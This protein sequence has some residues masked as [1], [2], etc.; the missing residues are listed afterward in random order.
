[1]NGS[2]AAGPRY[3]LNFVSRA[4]L[5]RET[6]LLAGLRRPG[7]SW[8]SVRDRAVRENAVQARTHRSGVRLTREAVRRLVVLS[9]DE[10]E[11]LLDAAPRE[12][13]YLTWAA[14]CRAYPFIG[15]FAEQV[16]RE[17]Y[18][19][20][21]L[22][23]LPEHLEAFVLSQAMWHAELADLSD[24]MESGIR[25]TVFRMMREADLVTSDGE[26][27]PALLSGRLAELLT[28]AGRNDL[29]FFPTRGA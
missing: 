25:Q 8:E 2:Y 4:L 24:S 11:F 14:A 16:L 7:E 10:V 27:V 28:A 23:I 29:R 26:I 1:M 9:D 13:G 12:R 21:A 22:T 19:I 15:D 3:A 6:T 18:L 5:V 20:L 17:R